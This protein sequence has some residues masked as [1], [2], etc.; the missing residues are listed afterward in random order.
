MG[1]RE[2][3]RQKGLSQPDSTVI[4]ERNESRE[5]KQFK[6]QQR[7]KEG[8]EADGDRWKGLN[9]GTAMLCQKPSIRKRVTY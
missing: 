6:L 5:Q 2:G 8:R 3:H 9:V 4:K 1:H 7:S